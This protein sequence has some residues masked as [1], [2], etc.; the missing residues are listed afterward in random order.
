MNSCSSLT[1]ELLIFFELLTSL[2]SQDALQEVRRLDQFMNTGR[3]DEFLEKVTEMC[4]F[5]NMKVANDKVKEKVQDE[6]KDN[7]KDKVKDEVMDKVKDE[8]KV[9]DETDGIEDKE[10][11]PHYQDD[12]H[13]F[14][15]RKGKHVC[16]QYA[17]R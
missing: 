7:V 1:H 10:E 3:A 12:L 9:K 17:D 13:A 16:H 14:Q 11:A 8:V 5:R 6:V 2:I 15:Y 4:S